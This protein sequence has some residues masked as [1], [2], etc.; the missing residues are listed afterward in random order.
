MKAELCGGPNDG[1]RF[2]LD[3]H[4]APEQ[5]VVPCPAGTFCGFPVHAQ[6]IFELAKIEGGVA[7]YR[8]VIV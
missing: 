6:S 7:Y 5:I 1:L 3:E 8:L 4:E 2:D